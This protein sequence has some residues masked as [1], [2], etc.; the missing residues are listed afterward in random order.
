M[1]VLKSRKKIGYVIKHESRGYWG[2]GWKRWVSIDCASTW[3]SKERVN[4][5]LDSMRREYPKTNF[6][7][8]SIK[9][10]YMQDH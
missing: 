1:K 6:G 10:L 9:T 4:E 5:G 3:R 8:V 7:A 2:A